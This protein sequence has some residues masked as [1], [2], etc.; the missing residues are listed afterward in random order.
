MFPKDISAVSGDICSAKYDG[1]PEHRRTPKGLRAY[2][3]RV[4]IAI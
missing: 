2:R 3:E 4:D 1:S